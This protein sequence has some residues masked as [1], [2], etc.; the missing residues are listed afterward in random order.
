VVQLLAPQLRLGGARL[1]QRG[2]LSCD[3]GPHVRRGVRLS[4][5]VDVPAPTARAAHVFGV[6]RVV[7]LQSK[8]VG[9]VLTPDGRCALP[10]TAWGYPYAA[11]PPVVL[12]RGAAET[13][14]RAK[15]MTD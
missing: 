1:D 6:A 12:R 8:L 5:N 11:L 14:E 2:R 10:A 13:A 9:G 3:G 4:R 15:F 7:V